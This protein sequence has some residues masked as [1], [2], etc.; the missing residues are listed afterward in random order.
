MH[1]VTFD[2]CPIGYAMVSELVYA[3]S[4]TTGLSAGGGDNL[5][6]QTATPSPRVLCAGAT[7][8]AKVKPR[9]LST[10]R[11]A[12]SAHDVTHVHPISRFHEQLAGVAVETEVTGIVLADQ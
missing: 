8:D 1:P 11:I 6:R 7:S 12:D 10:A 2:E 5:V 9:P 4:L 3:S